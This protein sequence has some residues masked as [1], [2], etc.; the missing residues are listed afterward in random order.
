MAITHVDDL[1][2][3]RLK[4]TLARR[5]RSV[6]EQK[7]MPAQRMFQDRAGRV[8]VGS[9]RRVELRLVDGGRD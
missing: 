9:E 4:R 3:A 8:G 5:E 6:E 2:R 1:W 7:R